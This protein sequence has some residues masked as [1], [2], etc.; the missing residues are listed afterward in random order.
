MSLQKN[1]LKNAKEKTEVADIV[2]IRKERRKAMITTYQFRI[3]DANKIKELKQMSYDVNMVW[4]HCN[5]FIR[6]RWKESR[7]YTSKYSLDPLTKGS[8]GF[9]KINSQSVQMVAY[10]LADSLKQFKK[11]IRFRSKKKSLGWI[12]FQGQ[13]FKFHGNSFVYNKKIY[14]IWKSRDL[15]IN[16]VIKCG[17][18]NEDSRGRWYVNI[19]IETNE[20]Q[21]K[22]LINE[23]VGVDLGLK[24]LAT[25]SDGVVYDRAN[26]TKKY[27]Q[28]LAKAQKYGKKRQA[29]KIHSKIKNSRMDFN[30]KVSHDLVKTYAT[31][32]VG[33]VSS[34]KLIKTKMAKSVHDAGWSQL[35]MFLKYKAIRHSGTFL[36][37]NERYSTVTCS[38][39]LNKTG[40]SGLS[41]LKIRE[42]SCNI[43][44]SLHDRDVNAAQNILR[45]GHETLRVE[46]SK[47]IPYLNNHF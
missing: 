38:S 34:S 31:V 21:E 32:I 2:F 15:P 14:K 9:L 36:E 24:T 16:S 26:L 25:C 30:H 8:S 17:S 1:C 23:A 43:C 7:K 11:P 10:E 28:K 6:K 27:E 13:T 4:N 39:C 42:W 5:E 33:D 18:I 12:P 46:R 20:L 29:K 19:Q 47:G 44:G 35:K 41:N 37:V 45:F 3:K 22:A 40:P